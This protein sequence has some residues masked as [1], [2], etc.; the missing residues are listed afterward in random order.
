VRR[1]H[2]KIGQIHLQERYSCHRM[3]PCPI[4]C[5]IP[6]RSNPPSQV[7]YLLHGSSSS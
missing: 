4:G 7:Q 6:A 5:G 2:L 1:S 3:R